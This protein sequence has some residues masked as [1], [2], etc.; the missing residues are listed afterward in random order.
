MW[1]D[2]TKME[3][4]GR[5]GKHYVWCYLN[6]SHHPKK[7]IPTVKHGGGCIM[8]WECFSSAGT[9]KPVRIMGMIKGAKYGEILE[10]NLF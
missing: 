10:E 3:L 9:G 2:E 1:L 7:T 4:F 6:T 5:Q 8:L